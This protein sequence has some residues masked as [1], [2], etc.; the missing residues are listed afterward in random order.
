MSISAG[1]ASRPTR[2]DDAQI[3]WATRLPR[4]Y[5]ATKPSLLPAVTAAKYASNN[6]GKTSAAFLLA[7]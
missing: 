3:S 5:A 2:A 7:T 1:C 4:H 6:A